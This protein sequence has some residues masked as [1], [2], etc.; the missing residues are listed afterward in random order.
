MKLVHLVGFYYK[1]VCYSVFVIALT[2]DIKISS[3]TFYYAYDSSFSIL[4]RSE[5]LLSEPYICYKIKTIAVIWFVVISKK[6]LYSSLFF[7]IIFT[8]SVTV[9]R[10]RDF[11]RNGSKYW[12][13]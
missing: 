8:F 5:E 1:E 7:F 11:E 9:Q 3:L 2:P 12:P 6:K 4:E 10:G 13:K